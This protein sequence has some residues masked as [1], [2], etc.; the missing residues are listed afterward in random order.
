MLNPVHWHIEPTSRCT[1]ECSG[2][3]RTWFKSTFGKQLIHDINV[4]DLDNFFTVNNF[5]NQ[6]IFLCGNNGD[7]I[8]HPDIHNLIKVCK[9]FGHTISID[10]NGSNKPKHF[11]HTLIDNLSESDTIVFAIDGLED[12]NALYRKNSNW[13]LLMDA[14]KIVAKSQVQMHWKFIPFNHNQHQIEEAQKLSEQL[15][16]DKFLLYPSNRWNDTSSLKPSDT[17]LFKNYPANITKVDPQCLSSTRSTTYID[18]EG[19]VY[20]CCWSG[21]YRFKF[22]HIFGKKPMNIKDVNWKTDFNQK[23]NDFFSDINDLETAPLM[24]KMHC[25]KC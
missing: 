25:G 11:W 18:A 17:E 8:Y 15:G 14:V 4:D 7:S 22:K 23:H 1:L 21:S 16:F 10:T 13:N 19:N 2:C 3:D 24:C 20:P 6:T 5:H 9:K 12:T